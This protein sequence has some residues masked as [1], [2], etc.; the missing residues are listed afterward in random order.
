MYAQSKLLL[1]K[2]NLKDLV[3]RIDFG[4]IDGLYDSNIENYFLDNS[5]WEKIVEDRTFFVIGRKGTGK[6]AIYNWIEK[7]SKNRGAL[8][9]NLSFKDFPFEKLLKLSDD[10]FSRPNQYQSIWR[11]II[12]SELASLIV[13][14]VLAIQNEQFKEL[15]RYVA[16]VF[17]DDI[18]D[19]HKQITKNATKNTSGIFIKHARYG[20]DVGLN[21]GKERGVEVSL[22]D[23]FSNITK[24]NRR[25]ELIVIDY[26]IAYPGTTHFIVQFDQLDDNYT[27]YQKLDEY[28]QSIISLFKVIYDLNQSLK[29]KNVKAKI[30]AYLRSDIFNSIDAF[31]S[32]SARWDR[33]KLSL[34]WSIVNKN[35]WDN[36][37]LLRLINKRISTSLADVS[38]SEAFRT[39]FDNRVIKLTENY[40]EIDIFKYI[41][42]RSFHRPRDIV[43]F[44]I[45][46]QE[47]IEKS[48]TYYFR[49]IKDAEKEYSLW[50]LS[51]LAN[52]IAVQVKE[53]ESLYLFL[54]LMG[55]GTFNLTDFK[56]RYK[57]Y[58]EKIGMESEILLKYLYSFGIILNV[59]Y[60]KDYTEYF[61]VIRNDKSTFN[62]DLKIQ[63]HPGFWKGLHTSTYIGKN[64]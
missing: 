10:D 38:E 58:E 26:L 64:N 37:A 13:K 25:L 32:E 34:N 15:E 62:R 30:I 39:V 53:L 55:A 59:N 9:S 12:L 35:D 18:I 7:R 48:D 4:D 3:K 36:P 24:I 50:L 61:S 22:G 42:H 8:I 31:D 57:S 5:Y 14:D 28:K 54:R 1:P 29:S 63:I 20:T 23:E 19:L 17:G 51:E 56:S 11:N 16:H 40:R 27:Q 43:Q 41:I 2:I 21:K 46:I 60:R 44:C 6:S 45:K 47:D 52:E 33:H 49:T